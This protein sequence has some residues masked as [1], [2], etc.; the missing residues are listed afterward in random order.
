[1]Q[2]TIQ[3]T[4][5][6]PWCHIRK[7]NQKHCFKSN[8]NLE[9]IKNIRMIMYGNEM[10]QSQSLSLGSPD[11]TFPFRIFLLL[12]QSAEQQMEHI[13]SWT[14]D[15]KAF[16]VHDPAEFEKQLLAKNFKM[17]KYASFTRQLCAYGFSCVRKGRQTGICK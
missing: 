3:V 8:K 5:L 14:P 10:R 1:M 4:V 6:Y 15:G 12:K 7:F 2:F 17:K 16:K 11:L 13:I 9:F